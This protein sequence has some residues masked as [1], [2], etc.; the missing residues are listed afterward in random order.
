MN[1]QVAAWISVGL[2]GIAL[3]G[4]GILLPSTIKL[5]SA[6]REEIRAEIDEFIAISDEAWKELRLLRIGRPTSVRNLRQTKPEDYVP[7]P[8]NPD[9]GVQSGQGQ[10]QCD[11]TNR[12]PPGPPGPSGPAGMDGEMGE[13][14]SPGTPGKI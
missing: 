8:I 5:G 12:C 2:S 3:L 4:C 11:V 9:I 13:K 14:G 6:M 1:V 7:P 10:C